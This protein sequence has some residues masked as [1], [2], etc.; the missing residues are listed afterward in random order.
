MASELRA[1]SNDVRHSRRV[2]AT[3]NE[4]IEVCFINT[5]QIVNKHANSVQPGNTVLYNNFVYDCV[6]QSKIENDVRILDNNGT[7]IV[8]SYMKSMA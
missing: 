4:V 1:L 2:K 5:E 7:K 6:D 8:I 3:K